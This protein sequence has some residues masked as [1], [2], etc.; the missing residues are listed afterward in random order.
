MKACLLIC[1]T[2]ISYQVLAQHT[3]HS[4][5]EESVLATLKTKT[6]YFDSLIVIDKASYWKGNPKINGFGFK[7]TSVFKLEISLK[8]NEASELEVNKFV[9]KKVSRPNTVRQLLINRYAF[10][11]TLNDDSLNLR[12]PRLNVAEPE[13]W[14]VLIMNHKNNSSLLKQSFAP[15]AFQKTNP[16]S[17]RGMFI[18]F[19]DAMEE[20]LK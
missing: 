16:T 7:G 20:Q 18:E 14:S 8:E 9:K 19:V 17:Q 15:R 11:S 12:P 1:F 10:V 13:I 4:L 3:P 5:K 2:I 6:E